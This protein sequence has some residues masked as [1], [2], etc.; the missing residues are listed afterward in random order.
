MRRV[1]ALNRANLIDSLEIK[2]A[3]GGAEANFTFLLR[4]SC[5]AHILKVV[6]AAQSRSFGFT[7]HA[8]N[9]EISRDT[10]PDPSPFLLTSLDGV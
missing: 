5:V 8:F 7:I 3:Q 4:E 9:H 6:R 2:L 10:T 1:R